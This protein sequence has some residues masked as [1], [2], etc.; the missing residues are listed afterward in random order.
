MKK[1]VVLAVLAATV[2]G[3]SPV[4]QHGVPQS[5]GDQGG[6]SGQ[7]P[8]QQQPVPSPTSSSPKTYANGLPDAIQLPADAT[9]VEPAKPID[10]PA[11]IH[12]WTAVATTS[13][14]SSGSELVSSIRAVLLTNGWEVSNKVAR[15][16]AVTLQASR[17]QPTRAWLN[18]TVTEPL[19]GAGPAL[20]YRYAS[21]AS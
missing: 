12:G 7:S 3:C 2:V 20:T 21:S 8:E 15:D 5:H 11:G 18:I 19:P 14:K 9:L 17:A 16:S 13:D 4:T 1:Y 6:Q 10:A